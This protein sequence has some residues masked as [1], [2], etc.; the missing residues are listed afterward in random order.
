ML[1]HG[2]GWPQLQHE[3]SKHQAAG[4]DLGTKEVTS[5]EI[6]EGACNRR[7]HKATNRANPP[8]HAHPSAEEVEIGAEHRMT[9]DRGGC[10]DERPHQVSPVAE[11]HDQTGLTGCSNPGEQGNDTRPDGPEQ[12]VHQFDTRTKKEW[13]CTAECGGA[14]DDGQHVEGKVAVSS[15]LC[16]GVGR[17]IEERDVEC[18]EDANQRHRQEHK[19][20]FRQ[21]LGFNQASCPSLVARLAEKNGARDNGQREV[22]EGNHPHSPRESD[23][24]LQSAEYDG[25]DDAAD[26]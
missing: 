17:D 7:S 2:I 25:E 16:T 22:E 12:D 5:I 11:P 18:Q 20:G 24:R 3:G 4:K 23:I 13:R 10:R 6:D 26:T 19:V 1:E 14:V 21:R 9:D 8:H 15:Q